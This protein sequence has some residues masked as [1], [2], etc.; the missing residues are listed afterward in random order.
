MVPRKVLAIVSRRTTIL[1]LVPNSNRNRIVFNLIT[2]EIPSLLI[3][4]RLLND[5]S[6]QS[7]SIYIYLWR[8]RQCEPTN[9]NIRYSPAV[10]LHCATFET[11]NYNHPRQVPMVRWKSEAVVAW[12]ELVVQ[13]PMYSKACSENV[14][15]GKVRGVG[16]FECGL[17]SAHACWLRMY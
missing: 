17:H 5:S 6:I 3:Q 7:I 14:K 8:K 1:I 16:I 11:F 13:M 12:L 15:S 2:S 4:A 10:A 9:E